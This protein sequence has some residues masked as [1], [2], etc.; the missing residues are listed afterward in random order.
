M[1]EEEDEEEIEK[2]GGDSAPPEPEEESIKNAESAFT[3]VDERLIT[4][5]R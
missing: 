4:G 5:N 1:D 3:S 2:V